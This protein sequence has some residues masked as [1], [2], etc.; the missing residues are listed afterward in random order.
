MHIARVLNAERN[1]GKAE[2]QHPRAERRAKQIRAVIALSADNQMHHMRLPNAKHILF[3]RL[4]FI[5][6]IGCNDIFTGMRL[7]KFTY[8]L[9]FHGI[10]HFLFC[11]DSIAWLFHICNYIP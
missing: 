5:N 7:N 11:Q 8:V 10:I 2:K 3:R 6:E 9:T 1:T 4:A